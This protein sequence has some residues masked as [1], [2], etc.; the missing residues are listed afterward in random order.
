MYRYKTTKR[1]ARGKQELIH[2]LAFLSRKSPPAKKGQ[3]LPK[4]TPAGRLPKPA[5]RPAWTPSRDIS[6]PTNAKFTFILTPLGIESKRKNAATAP[7]SEPTLVGIFLV[8]L[9][10]GTTS[11]V[12]NIQIAQSLAMPDHPR[13]RSLK[14]AG[15][16]LSLQPA[17][18]ILAAELL[19]GDHVCG[20]GLAGDAD[21]HRSERDAA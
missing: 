6:K 3:S 19:F 18:P 15:R 17:D 13:R 20:H 11:V 16:K 9:I 7:F 21:G 12:S 2:C 4:S 10:V 1:L 8:I 5:H 14:K